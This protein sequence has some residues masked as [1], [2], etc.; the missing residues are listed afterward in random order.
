MGK[1]TIVIPLHLP[2][3][4]SADYQ[5][6]TCLELAKKHQVIILIHNDA[7][8]W[9]K[10]LFTKKKYPKVQNIVFYRPLY[11]I[12]LQRIALI[13]K[14]N[15]Y[16]SFKLIKIFYGWKKQ[17]ILWIFDAELNLYLNLLSK[18]NLSLYDNVDYCWR[19]NNNI[20]QK[21]EKKLIQTVDFFIVN[22]HV[23]YELNKKI[24]KADLIAPQGFRLND[25][26]K[27]IFTKTKFPKNKPLIGY[28]G[29]IN[30]RFDFPLLYKLIKNNS[31]W[32]FVIWG[33]TQIDP[34]IKPIKTQSQIN[35]LLSLD[36]VFSG[37]SKNKKEL[38]SIIKQFD[39]CM[40]PYNIK[41][42]FNH[43]CYPMKLFEYFYMGKPVVSTPIEELKRFPKYVKIEDTAQEWE[44]QIK[45]L[46]TKP[47]S[48]KYQ[49]KQKKLAINNSWEKKI[50]IISSL[51]D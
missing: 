28:I 3:N 50:K 37:L 40:I 39:I 33:P 2:W 10:A 15:D 26:E 14:I 18:N 41:Y 12:P 38:S 30:Y 9:L 29:G 17:I 24:R 32:N 43:Y 22:S 23:L 35:K 27:P 8:F 6:Q 36:N 1:K 7:I 20:I 16:L 21:K 34:N 25:F 45:Q 51:I 31:Q 48:K 4:W 44:K 5:K 42:K 46:L 49:Q 13:K 11:L 19:P 47:W